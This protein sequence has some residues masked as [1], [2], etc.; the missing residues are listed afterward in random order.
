MVVFWIGSYEQSK[1]HPQGVPLRLDTGCPRG[2]RVRRWGVRTGGFF[3]R[4]HQGGRAPT[5]G[6]PTGGYGVPT[7]GEV[8][9]RGART[10]GFFGRA[11]QGGRAPTRG[12]PTGGYGVPT[13][14][15]DAGVAVS[16]R[17]DFLGARTK[18]GG[19]PQGVPL[20]VDT[21]CPR[22]GR[23]RARACAYGWIFWAR[24]PRGEGT[25]KGC[26]YGWIR[27]AHEGGGVRAW[28]V[29]TGGFFGR[30]HQGGR[31]PTRGAPTGGYGVPTKGESAGE[32]VHAYGWIFWARAPRGEGT[33]KGCPYG[34]IRGA[35]EGGECVRGVSV[36]VDF[37][38][39]RTKGGGHPQGVPLRVDTGCPRGGRVR[40]WGGT[41][42]FFGR[43]HQGGRAPTRGAPTGGYGVPTRGEDAG[44]GGVRTG[45]FFGRAHQGGRAPTRGAPTGG[46]GVPTRGACEGVHA[47][48]WIFWA[49]APRGEGTHKGC[50]YGWIRGA[51]EGGECVRGG[52]RV[53]VD[54]LGART[55]GGGHPQGVPL[56][57]DTGC[58]R[59]GR[60]RARGVRTGGFFGRAHQGG[61]APT[62]GAPTGGYGVPTKGESACEG[63]HAYGWIFWARAPR[64]EGTHKGCPYGWIRGA[65][66]GG[67]CVRGGAR[68][69][70]DFLGART[71]G[72]GHPQGVPLR[73]DTGCPRRG[74]VRARGCTRTGGF[75]GRAH[76]GGR[77]PTRGA[78]TG[79][80]GVPTRGESAG[81][82]VHAYG[83]IFW[84]RAP[85][86]EGTHKGCPYGWI[87]GAHE[88]GGC[89]RG[90]VRTGGFF[91]RAHQGGRAPTRGAPT[92]GYGVPT[93]GESACEGVRV[94]VD[95]LGARTKGG[96][97][98]QGVPLRVDTG[99]PRGG[100]VR[101]RACA[102]GWIFWAR[103]PRG[104]GTHKGCP[105]G[106]IRGAHEGGECVRGGARVRVDFLGART[107]G[108]GHPQGVPL[109]DAGSL[110]RFCRW[111]M[112]LPGRSVGQSHL[113]SD[114]KIVLRRARTR[115]GGH[116]QGVPLR[117]AG[118]L[119]RFCRWWMRLAW[120]FC[121][122]I[123]SEFGRQN[124]L[125]RARTRGGR[126]PTRGALR[127]AGSLRRFC[128]WWMQLAWAFCWA[129][130][131]EFGRQNSLRWARTRGGRAPTRGAPTGCWQPEEVLSLVDAVGLG[132]L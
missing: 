46:Y 22:G 129:I 56:R 44:E 72:G 11:H 59:G 28:G 113:N 128:R 120:A 5:R 101:A 86:G 71:K 76:Q 115:G 9:A 132:V 32:G 54:F 100:R 38:G 31:A 102:Y 112:R 73:V 34:W 99:C 58:P 7:R 95:F 75:F 30:A 45:G 89:G 126:A 10:G 51:H 90:G 8:R 107:K 25:H 119:R 14:G 62:R 114:A 81:E 52:A 87:R 37:L 70:V 127:D 61:R 36:R 93:K 49:R 116:P 19:H 57:V 16:V 96:G 85:R 123:A 82:G 131:S 117:D 63:V 94:R 106:W 47:Y 23:V 92:G 53:R 43:A 69:R 3:G 121:R 64:G 108:G 97:H 88:G 84:A 109:R 130:A 12:A 105:Y 18:G 4:A 77:A 21:G 122:A 50:P 33:H 1:G 74:R 125:R 91:G 60:V 103:A 104:E 15:E 66:E 79:G 118:S 13:R 78:P 111:W 27:G 6:A 24:A 20:R 26:P 65:H 29:R 124:S 42:G 68:V 48:G 55:K 17:V 2:G 67:E 39:A 80:Y 41:G 110:R 35:H 83:W 40:A 98:P